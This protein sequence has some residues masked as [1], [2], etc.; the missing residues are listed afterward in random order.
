MKSMAMHIKVYYLDDGIYHDWS[1][2]VKTIYDHA[3]EKNKRFIKQKRL[4]GR[5]WRRHLVC[6]NLGG[7]LFGTLTEHGPL[8]PCGRYDYICD[9][10]Q[11]D[12]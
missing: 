11:H 1:T 10:A 5:T 3:E 2:L 7:L 9:H 6:S 12:L 4:I 8:R